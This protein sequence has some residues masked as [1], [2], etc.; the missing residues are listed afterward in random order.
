LSNFQPFQGEEHKTFNWFGGKPAALLIH[1][2]P[3]TP[4]ELRP[5]GRSLH[6]AGWT[7]QGPLLPGFGPEIATLPQRQASEWIEAVRQVVADLQSRHDPVILIG[8][9]M[10]AALAVQAAVAQPP[11]GL[12]LVAPFQRLGTRWQQLV[13]FLMKPFLRH[14]RPFKKA[15][16]SDPEVREGFTRFFGGVSLDDP[17]IQSYLRELTVPISLLEQIQ[18]VGQTA[19]RSAKEITQP[20]L[21]LQGTHDEVVNPR[22]T[23]RLM[24]RLSGPIQYAE[25]VGGHDL[26]DPDRPTWPK[27]EQAVLSFVD[28]FTGGAQPEQTRTPFGNQGEQDDS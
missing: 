17:E 11:T 7:V 18:R 15:D 25:L 6:Q 14:M 28:S 9:S 16:F 12:V 21:V 5:L 10:G 13:G 4:A 26:L 19:S 22:G 1:G 20:V 2:F 3:G 23:R 24:Q 27:L 8:Y